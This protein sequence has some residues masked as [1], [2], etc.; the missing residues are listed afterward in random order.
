MLKNVI[1]FV[2]GFIFALGLGLSGM[3]Q[4]HKVIG[5]LSLFKNWD[6]TLIFVM[7]GALIVHFFA[8]RFIKNKKSPLLDTQWHIP[9][10]KEIT[11]SLIIGSILFGIGWGIA[12]Y[13]PGPAIVSLASFQFEPLFFFIFLILGMLLFQLMARMNIFNLKN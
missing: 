4:P 6:P 13:C 8:Y 9:T 11:P 10:K 3:T 5:F 12:G 2:S 1:V 7:I